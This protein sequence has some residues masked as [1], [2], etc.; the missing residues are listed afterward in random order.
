MSFRFEDFADAPSAQA[1]FAARFPIGSPADPAL[2][3]LVDMGAQCKNIAPGR[4]ACRYV[5]RGTRLA[6][7][8]WHLVL[9][10]DTDRT[11][12]RAGVALALL[13]M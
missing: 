13:G 4:I 9:D 10:C 11:I 3:V 2:Q 8:A 5:E 1:A 12:K 7:F 6:G